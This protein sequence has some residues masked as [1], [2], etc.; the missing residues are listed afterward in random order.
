MLKYLNQLL[1][2]LPAKKA[3]LLRMVIL[4]VLASVLEVVGI[5][6]VGPFIALA[7]NTNLIQKNTYLKWLFEHSG[8]PSGRFI[9]IIG[10][11]VIFTFCTKTFVSWFTQAS[12]TRFSD[13]QQHLLIARMAR[14]YL[15]APYIY[16][17][18]KNTLLSLIMWLRLPIPSVPL[19]STHY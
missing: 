11:F 19:F 2:I 18:E 12:I 13:Q 17:T 7:N 15:S 10:L 4:F 5:G 16:N 6:V 14:E 8:L 1:Y 3:T 9:A